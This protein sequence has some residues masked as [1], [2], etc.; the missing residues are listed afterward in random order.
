MRDLMARGENA[1]RGIGVQMAPNGRYRW[2]TQ[3]VH[4]VCAVPSIRPLLLLG[5]DVP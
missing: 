1:M 4:Y 5:D 3:S 2:D